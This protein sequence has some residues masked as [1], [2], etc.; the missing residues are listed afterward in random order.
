MAGRSM[1]EDPE[2]KNVMKKLLE[3]A[4]IGLECLD[5]GAHFSFEKAEQV[6]YAAKG[7]QIPKRCADCRRFRR[8]AKAARLAKA[9]SGVGPLRIAR[10]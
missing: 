9:A 3:D 5:C 10:K 1:D 2:S 8:A 7:Y 6:H 4:G